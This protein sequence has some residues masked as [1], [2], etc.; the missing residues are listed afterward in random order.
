MSVPPAAVDG[1][2]W[3]AGFDEAASEQKPL[4]PCRNT[5]A[6]RRG[7]DIG[8][9]EAITFADGRGFGVEIE[10]FAGSRTEQQIPGF[11]LEGINCLV[12][13]VLV[14]E[15]TELIELVEEG[16]AIFNAVDGETFCGGEVGDSKGP[17]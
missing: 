9:S 12:A 1:D 7:S 6:V 2:E 11:R 14:G 17:V 4:A 5:A 10:R 16:A 13:G 3:D 15:A 8:G